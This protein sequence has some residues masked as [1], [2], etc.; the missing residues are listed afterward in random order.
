MVVS[1]GKLLGVFFILGS[2]VI[3]AVLIFYLFKWDRSLRPRDRSRG[4]KMSEDRL[5]PLGSL[6][7]LLTQRE[8]VDSDHCP[9]C[10]DLRGRGI[11]APN[12]LKSAT[13]YRCSSPSCRGSSFLQEKKMNPQ[14]LPAQPKEAEIDHVDE[15]NCPACRA[16]LPILQGF[17]VGTFNL[18][19]RKCPQPG[20]TG[21]VHFLKVYS[22]FVRKNRLVMDVHKA[23]SVCSRQSKRFPK[24]ATNP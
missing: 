9:A 20:C 12:D 6:T 1:V 18:H 15:P 21:M 17:S 13:S 2:A 22:H 19:P 16:L 8:H 3:D 11:L 10:W 7:P 24:C 23:C 5:V 4:V 14:E